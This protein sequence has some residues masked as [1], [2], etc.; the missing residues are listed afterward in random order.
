VV[1]VR[2]NVEEPELFRNHR[3][4]SPPVGA[5]HLFLAFKPRFLATTLKATVMIAGAQ[6]GVCCL[7]TWMPTHLKTVKQL[8]T[9]STGG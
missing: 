7:L 9:T 4:N 1:W 5:V 8:S 6:G 3:A 2:R